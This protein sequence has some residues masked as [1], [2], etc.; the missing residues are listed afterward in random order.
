MELTDEVCSMLEMECI[1]QKIEKYIEL[2]KP[3]MVLEHEYIKLD[4]KKSKFTDSNQIN[5]STNDQ[6]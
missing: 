5:S 1:H 4:D 3:G 2:S 6:N